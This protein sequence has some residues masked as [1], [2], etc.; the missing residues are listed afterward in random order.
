MA[1]IPD[2]HNTG[3]TPTQIDTAFSNALTHTPS[4]STPAMDGT[5]AA[6]TADTFA[7]GDHVHPTDTSRQAALTTAQ[8]AAVNSGIDSTKVQQIE[9]NKTNIILLEEMNGK[10]N[11]AT[12]N[13]FTYTAGN[14][15]A[16]AYK[17][18][19]L[20]TSL[21]GEYVI[22]ISNITSDAT[23]NNVWIRFKA[24]DGTIFDPRA[25]TKGNNITDNINFGSRVPSE[26]WVYPADS[27][28]SSYGKTVTATNIMII[29]KS[30]YDAGFTG[31]QPYAMSNAELTEQNNIE[32]ISSYVTAETG[33]TID[34]TTKLIKQGKHIFGTAKINDRG[35][36]VIPKKAREL[37][38]INNGDSLICLGDEAAGIA[39][40]KAD[41]FEKQINGIWNSMKQEI[42]E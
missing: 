30:I 26:L 25:V 32:D 38:G 13:S 39:L 27:L 20:I 23:G 6:G 14:D 11:V 22:I 33:Y 1:V 19:P 40:I 41:V 29:P 10:K 37:F 3:L 5:G 17:K 18:I 28:A 36:V 7:R 21:S 34:S 4:S 8:L 31:Y 35:Q 9:T 15:A 24:T 42:S 12:I 2:T 16:T